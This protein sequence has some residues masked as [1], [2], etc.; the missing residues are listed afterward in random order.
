MQL[1]KLSFRNL[2]SYGNKLQEFE[3]STDPQLILVEG[4]NGGGKSTISDALTFAIYGKSSIR[5]TKELPNR[6]NKNGYTFIDFI[7]S[8]G[9]HIQIE[10]GLEP[11]FSR[12]SINDIE[13]NLPDKRRTDEF[14]EEQLA[15]MPFNVFSNTIS[16]SVNDFKSF[17][18]LSPSDKRQ[19]IDRIFGLEIVNDMAKKNKD[20]LKAL[21]LTLLS[22][23]NKI[24]SSNET[25]K[26]SQAQL[27]LMKEDLSA[28]KTARKKEVSERLAALNI[29]LQLYK[30]NYTDFSNAVTVLE[31]EV[32]KARDASS[33]VKLTILDYAKK[34]DLYKTNKKCPHCLSDLTDSNHSTIK[35]HLEKQKANEEKELPLLDTRINHTNT[36]LLEKK[37]EQEFAKDRYYQVNALITPLKRELASLELE[38]TSTDTD[39]T[40][41]IKELIEKLEKTISTALVEQ[42]T[43]SDQIKVLQELEEALS[44]NGMKRLLM[45]QIIPILN[46]KILRTAKVLD[47]PFAFEFDMNFE[48]IITQLGIQISADSLSTGEQKKMNLIVLLGIIE[49]IKLKNHSVNLL[50]LD[51]IFSSLDVES[52][53]R[54]VD[55]LKTFSKKYKMTIFVIS[56]D[57]LPEELFDRKLSVKKVDHF[58]DITF[59]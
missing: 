51:E 32:R 40:V 59:S 20:D 17:V 9:D 15:K 13:H 25:I 56:H 52:I 6:S 3:F 2:C 37:S 29:D 43:V 46:K 23:N 34:L 48:P 14:I 26:E 10:R 8:T 38:D 16:L 47:F 49:L 22:L 36:L 11:N 28:S 18:K 12:L 24:Q 21:K 5:K 57:P 7:T 4:K 31:N 41:Y 19:I 42:E 45:S 39:G 55:L 1:L 30:T 33:A 27:D 50:F 44:D 54:V 58:S 53:Y 35:E